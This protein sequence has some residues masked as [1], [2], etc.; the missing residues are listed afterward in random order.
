MKQDI[1]LANK[2]MSFVKITSLLLKNQLFNSIYSF[3]NQGQRF[4]TDGVHRSFL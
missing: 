4:K 1:K 2:I 3:F